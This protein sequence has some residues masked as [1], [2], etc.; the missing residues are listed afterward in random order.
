MYERMPAK[1]TAVMRRS[2]ESHSESSFAGAGRSGVPSKTAIV[3]D[4]NLG[5]SGEEDVAV[6]DGLVIVGGRVGGAQERSRLF[7]VCC[8]IILDKLKPRGG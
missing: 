1:R 4:W 5:V 2:I 8:V 6:G 7:T 3:V